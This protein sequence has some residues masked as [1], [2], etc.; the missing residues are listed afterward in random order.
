MHS[1]VTGFLVSVSVAE[2]GGVNVTRSD[3]GGWGLSGAKN[4]LIS[5]MSIV[6]RGSVQ[7]VGSVRP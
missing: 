2:S 7:S 4:S 5:S 6:L 1:S 3:D